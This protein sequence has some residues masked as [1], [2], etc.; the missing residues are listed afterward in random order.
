MIHLFLL[1]VEPGLLKRGRE[2]S[3]IPNIPCS[4]G[5]TVHQHRDL[6]VG[7]AEPGTV[8]MVKRLRPL[9]PD[10]LQRST[11]TWTLVFSSELP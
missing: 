2:S 5:Q 8:S 6:W 4:R 10:V 3:D 1:V 9:C 11:P 7:V